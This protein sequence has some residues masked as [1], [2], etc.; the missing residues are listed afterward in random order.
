MPASFRVRKLEPAPVTTV[1]PG[2]MPKLSQV[3]SVLAKAFTNDVFTAVVTGHTPGEPDTGH[4]GPFWV[5]TVVAGLL[6]GE[7]YIA[8]TADTNE[9]VGCA[10][11]F[12]PGHTMYDT[13][14]QRK[15]SLGPLMGSFSKDLVD[16]WHKFLHKYDIFLTTALGENT[17]HNS[18]HLQ[19]LGVDPAYQR[20]GVATQLI[21]TVAENANT[22]LCVEVEKEDNLVIYEHLGFKV[23]AKETFTGIKEDHVPMWVMTRDPK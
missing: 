4:I 5:S 9:I 1:D 13:E 11:W 20:K 23:V 8:E 22:L 18:W 14:E 15:H 21:N 12:G 19:T 6:G 10:V 7:V 3:Q 2:S 16:W 17:K